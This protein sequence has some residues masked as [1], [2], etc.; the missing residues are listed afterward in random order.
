VKIAVVATSYPRRQ[1]DAA[2]HFVAAEVRAL[3]AAGHD[4][5]LIVPDADNDAFGWPGVLSRVAERPE[6]TIGVARFALAAARSLARAKVDRVIAH[7]IVP[8]AW[9]IAL[10]C[11]APL[12]VVAHGSDVR[13]LERCPRSFS[14]HV[15]QT[16]L[17][18][19]AALRFVSAELRARLSA[20]TGLE[21]EAE[22]RIELPPID[23]SAAP[24]RAAA[25]RALGI[26]QGE[27]L[28]LVVAR[29]VLKKRVDV[30]LAAASLFGVE[31]V[32]LGDGPERAWLERRFPGARF[33]GNV[34]HPRALAWI[35]AA[36]VLV[37]AS[38]HEGAPTAIR[39]ARALGVPVVSAAAGDL[40]AWAER[41][42]ELYL[43]G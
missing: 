38:R 2:G 18:R 15:V 43:I 6:R 7:W 11:D 25:R 30:A 5:V 21:L 9:P 28:V 31:S 3:E 8:S 40:R 33:E 41:D 37:S 24:S 1:D 16:L 19:K 42:R 26:S 32:V 39:E 17:A 35:A 14:R 34:P 20:A 23:V 10:A 29:L 22:S 12:E 36:D 27:R 4:V 13:L